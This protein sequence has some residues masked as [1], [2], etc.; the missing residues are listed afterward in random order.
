MYNDQKEIADIKGNTFLRKNH[1]YFLAAL[2]LV[3]VLLYGWL[4]V[5]T[6]GLPFVMDNN[7]TFSS[8]WHAASLH[9]FGFA[10]TYGLADE[11]FSP[12][13]AAHPY[14]HSHQGNFPRLFAW[15][16]YELGARSAESQ[17]VVTTFT[18]GLGT[19]ILMFLFFS[20]IATPAFAFLVCLVFMTD[21][22][23]FA[24]WQVVTYRVWYG[25]LLFLI[26]WAIERALN[27]STKKWLWL[28]GAAS[29]CLLYFE[30]VF[31]AFAGLFSFFWLIARSYKKPLNV[32][33]VGLWM[34]SG[35]AIGLLVF[36]S[37]AIGYLGWT[38][39]VR[40]IEFT[41]LARNDTANPSELLSQLAS[42]YESRH[43]IFWHNLRDE[44]V[45]GWLAF[46]RSFTAFDWQIHTPLLSAV[47]GV[48][49]LGWV[50]GMLPVRVVKYQVALR[51]G[52]GGTAEVFLLFSIYIVLCLI[53]FLLI[54]NLRF[55]TG[56]GALV[57]ST[58]KLI[59]M[60]GVGAMISIWVLAALSR[61][62]SI[63][64]FILL[65]SAIAIGLAYFPILLDQTYAPLWQI[66]VKQLF[67]HS[68]NAYNWQNSPLLSA[69]LGVLLLGW[70]LGMLPMRTS[71]YQVA[72][73][74][75][76]SGAGQVFQ[77]FSIYLVLCLIGFL[78]L[79]NLRYVNGT[80]AFQTSTT[81]LVLI[82]SMGAMTLIWVLAAMS[83]AIPIIHF[84][85]LFSAVAIGLAYYPILLDQTYAPLWQVLHGQLDAFGG[86]AMVVTAIFVSLGWIYARASANKDKSSSR[87]G[88]VFTYIFVGL[89]AYAAVYYLSAGYIYSG[90]LVRHAPFTVFIS[91]VL[92]AVAVYI[93]CAVS[94]R[95]LCR[96]GEKIPKYYGITLGALSAGLAAV[97]M[98]FW[99]TLQLSY[100]RLMPP[101][102]YAF[103]KKLSLPP[104]VGASMVVNNYPAPVA[105]YTG[106]WAYSDPGISSGIRRDQNGLM[107]LVGDRRYL[108]FADRETNSEY[109]RPSYFVCM[110]PQTPSSVLAGILKS[111]HQG[112]GHPGCSQLSLVRLAEAKILPISGLSLVALDGEGNKRIGFDSWAI[113]KIDWTLGLDELIFDDQEK[114]LSAASR[115]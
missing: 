35:A 63:I 57:T 25:F 66:L 49:L 56:V 105:A 83:R 45:V 72:V 81:K 67:S 96:D 114:S 11:V 22:L 55:V 4:I 84:I 23:L 54:W 6:N 104:F 95:F 41:Y 17:I 86:Q 13:A 46:A 38:D 53:G 15:L 91:D 90:Y 113:V 42:F 87:L 20:R 115:P 108:W 47:I 69:A 110:I 101:D 5:A 28:L 44:K 2:G 94:Y 93:V 97:M 112:P 12:H 3:Y 50:V 60:S 98:G 43:V 8:L 58:P 32:F 33:R 40:D 109:R 78:L 65:F 52:R 61:V 76:K 73:R 18:I 9:N 59:A 74:D 92:V 51:Y 62:I 14:I 70:V 36:V 48:L 71:K 77:L 27:S 30:L 29:A 1:T 102:H 106:N 107:K 19:I 68:Q 7:E 64:H 80:G 75:G 16:I 85:L 39:F 21:Y 34:A 10:K 24:Q 100:V 82:S 26:L 103:L 31:A 111:K 79:W 99:I 89:L 37:Q 88:G